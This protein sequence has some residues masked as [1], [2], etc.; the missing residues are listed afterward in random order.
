[1]TTNQL[2]SSA[3]AAF[4][5]GN[6]FYSLQPNKDTQN[7]PPSTSVTGPVE[8]G[9]RRRALVVDDVVDVTDMLAVLLTDAGYDVVTASS[10]LGALEIAGHDRF[11]VVISDIGMPEMNGYQLAR[12]LRAI[13]G[14]ADVPLVA[15]TGYS[16]FNDREESLRSGFTAHMTKPIDPRELL[17][18]I[19]QL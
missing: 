9:G 15:V 13:P 1:M 2:S 14:Y 8:T 11:D 7:D 16:M 10:A 4:I 17:N 3:S 19:D 18:L 12:A 6:F 5:A